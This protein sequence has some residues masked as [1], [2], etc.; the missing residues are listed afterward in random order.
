MSRTG[1]NLA[2]AALA[3]DD[4]LSFPCRRLIDVHAEDARALPGEEHRDRLAITPAR[5]DRAAAGQEHHLVRQPEHA[6]LI[7]LDVGGTDHGAP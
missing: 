1:R 4:C 3:G 2:G 5:T 6:R 7:D